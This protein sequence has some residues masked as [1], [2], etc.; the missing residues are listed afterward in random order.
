[1][2]SIKTKLVISFSVLM[3]LLATV[4][5][6]VALQIG[7]HSLQEEAEKSVQLLAYEGAKVTE[8]R[9]E[10]LI[11]VLTLLS[12]KE[13]IRDMGWEVDIPMIKKELEKTEFSDLAYVLPNG[14]AYFSDGTQ[15]HLKERSYVKKAFEGKA[16]ISD[17]MISYVTYEPEVIVAVP[18]VK[19]KEVVGVLLGC[20]DANALSDI[21]EDTGYG[22]SGY[23]YM[24]NGEGTIIA[25]PEKEFVINRYN[26]IQEAY[27]NKE[28]R[29]EAMM[30]ETIINKQNGVIEYK[31]DKKI[32]FG[33]FAPIKGT[34]WIFVIT[35]EE[36]EVLDAIP[37]M[38][39]AIGFTILLAM[40]I[41][42]VLIY[43]LGSSIAKPIIRLSKISSKFAELDISE[44]IDIRYMG[45]TDEIGILS[46]ALQSIKNNL[47][48]IIKQIAYSSN[49]VSNSA[50]LLSGNVKKSVHMIEGVSKS[51]EEIALGST[52]QS[53]NTEEGVSQV[54]I[55]EEMIEKNGI[56]I[57]SMNVATDQVTK[58]L[59]EGLIDI[60]NLEKS[61]EENKAATT[62]IYDLILE[63]KESS[64]KIIE[65]SKIIA[66]LAGQTNL[67]A[68]NASIEAVHAGEY[69]HGF[70]VV[71]Q[72]IKKMAEQSAMSTKMIDVIVNEIQMKVN[73]A[74]QQ[75][76]K[77]SQLTEV[78]GDN[79]TKTIN[80][81]HYIVDSMR[82]SQGSV[83]ELNTSKNNIEI[84]KN[85]IT[86][87]M[88]S[89]S[90]I[91]QENAAGTE[92]VASAMEEQSTF[93]VEMAS[94]SERLVHLSGGLKDIITRFKL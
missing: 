13:E 68:L 39:N 72:E 36:T 30:V 62:E 70:A 78:S 42:I 84:A 94:A 3:V 56:C 49:Q 14:Y 28:L 4:I 37:K 25:H 59:T 85:K 27:E 89:L 80:R 15:R 57:R 82:Q 73:N 32:F 51:V 34:D 41:G 8:S 54:C 53:V 67:L 47:R 35:A 5:G 20:K 24:M 43:I 66:E 9:M 64:E 63:T 83:S 44:D 88:Q 23:G 48:E 26:A 18:V 12:K 33:G 87:M 1:M 65:A 77:V 40:V 7:K 75:I 71:A 45:R 17:V 52:E 16:N 58:I 31:Q 11:K 60:K 29:N 55:L 76:K 46:N 81:F 79:V 38:I 21:T 91:A 2:K 90:A 6:M 19:E 10:A 50:E 22:D 92:E 74:V 61:T 69:G 93:M 86:E